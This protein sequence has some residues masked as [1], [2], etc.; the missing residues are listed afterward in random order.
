[1][2]MRELQ[3]LGHQD[4]LAYT[5]PRS[6]DQAFGR[7]ID[8]SEVVAAPGAHTPRWQG[9]WPTSPTDEQIVT[10]NLVAYRDSP[11]PEPAFGFRAA[12]VCVGLA[13]VIGLFVIGLDVF[14]WR[15]N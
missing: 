12:G 3:A 10:N 7:H 8:S 6:L 2:N 9:F 14:L 5:H 1:M 11:L 13:V 15:P 4:L